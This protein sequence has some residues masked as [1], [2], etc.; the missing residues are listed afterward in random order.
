MDVE[1]CTDLTNFSNPCTYWVS[2]Y[3]VSDDGMSVTTDYAKYGGD[4]ISGIQAVFSVSHETLQNGHAGD[5]NNNVGPY[6]N[7]NGHMADFNYSS[8]EAGNELWHGADLGKGLF[9][10]AFD[11]L[12][13]DDTTPTGRQI[14][15]GHLFTA[16]NDLTARGSLADEIIFEIYNA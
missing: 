8:Y 15:N 9:Q 14:E 3:S 10:V 2:G 13:F 4:C 11:S 7:S 1:V 16:I 6:I 12:N 5:L